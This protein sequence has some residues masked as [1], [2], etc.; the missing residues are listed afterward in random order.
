MDL[1]LAA[2]Y[3]P[4]LLALVSVA[5]S[6]ATTGHVLLYKRDPRAAVGWLGLVWVAPLAGPLLYWLLGINRIRRRARLL[7]ADWQ[8]SALPLWRAAMSPAE[9]MARLPVHCHHLRHLAELTERLTHHPLMGDNQILPLVNGDTAY[10]EMVAAIEAAQRSVTLTTYIFDNDRWGRRF[11]AALRRAH[12]RG[13]AVRV[14]V[15]AVGARYSWPP[16]TWGLRRDGVPTA[17]FLHALA[18]WKLRYFNLRN[19]RK[20]LVVDGAVGFT[21][22]MNLRAGCVLGDRPRHPVQDLHF[23]V[24]GPAVAQLQRVF[25]EDWAFTTGER[26]T[27]ERWFP[28]L[29]ERGLAAARVIT[30]GPDESFD[31]LRFTLL[32]ALTTARRRVLIQTPYFLPDT[33]LTTALRL[34]ALRGVAVEILLPAVNNLPVVHWAAMAGLDPLLEEGCRIALTPPPFDHT[35]LFVVDEAWSLFG[36]ANWDPRSLQLNF[37]V[38]VEVYDAGLGAALSDH[39]AR[40]S[41]TA[42]PLTCDDLCHRPLA[43]RLRDRAFHLAS[44]YL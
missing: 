26:L 43:A 8:P 37:E 24:E 36:S 42:R 32:A 20:I 16:I 34:A 1:S 2:R 13:V 7:Y 6:L 44:P 27:G 12:R 25:A 9:A 39:F 14:L 15:D 33:E 28:P 23:R 22:G 18:P 3:W 38:A 30:D 11:R 17:R 29:E 40:R 19:H 41:A 4:H 31:R 5:V 10:P 21:G 35:K